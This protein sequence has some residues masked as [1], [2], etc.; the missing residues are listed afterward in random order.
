MSVLV[1]SGQSSQLVGLPALSETTYQRLDESLRE[2][3]RE[4]VDAVESTHTRA[5]PIV[6]PRSKDRPNDDG[7]NPSL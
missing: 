3:Y 2:I 1:P 4:Y 7:T 5:M 6:P